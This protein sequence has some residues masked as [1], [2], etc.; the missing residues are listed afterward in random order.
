MAQTIGAKSMRSVDVHYSSTSS[1][2]WYE[3]SGQLNAI[4]ASGGDRITGEAFTADGDTAVV[5][6]GKLEPIDVT[7]RIIYTEI[8]AEA[9]IDLEAL[10]EAGTDIKLSWAP[11]GWVA[12]NLLFRT[13]TTNITSFGYPGGDVESG[14]PILV[15]FA[16]KTSAITVAR[17]T[18]GLG[19]Y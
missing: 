11:G 3:I 4:E 12:G 19:T 2:L 17:M 1:W 7:G 8:A 5:L 9:F 6:Y 15:E 14:D 13:G 10:Y 16:V 18:A